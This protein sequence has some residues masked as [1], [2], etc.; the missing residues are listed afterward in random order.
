MEQSNYI[1]FAKM[2]GYDI[3]FTGIGMGYITL[4][5]IKLT[6]TEDAEAAL[7]RLAEIGAHIMMD[8]LRGQI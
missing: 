4:G 3:V 5:P 8:E 2:N 1:T 6:E 7:A